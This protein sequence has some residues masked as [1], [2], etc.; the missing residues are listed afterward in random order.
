MSGREHL[1]ERLKGVSLLITK[2][3]GFMANLNICL[4]KNNTK[5]YKKLTTTN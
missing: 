3:M 1:R 5:M 2:L 4:P